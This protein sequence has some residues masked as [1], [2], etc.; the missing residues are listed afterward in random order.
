MVNPDGLAY[1]LTEA[2]GGGHYRGWRKNRQPCPAS[3]RRHRPQS[4]LR[5]SLGLLRRLVGEPG[6]RDYRGPRAW[7]APEVRAMRDFVHSRVVGGRQRIRAHITFHTAGELVLW[8]YGYTY[9][10]CRRT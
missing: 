1:D 8:P 6:R 2:H 4:Q 5:L 3:G 7:S 9:R 10:T